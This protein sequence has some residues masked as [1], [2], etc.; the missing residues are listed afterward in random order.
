M[1]NAK[2]AHTKARTTK[3][4]ALNRHSLHLPCRQ[5]PILQE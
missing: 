5:L 4:H 3:V 2:S 1:V